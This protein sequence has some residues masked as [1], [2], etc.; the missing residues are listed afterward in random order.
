MRR[1][2]LA[3]A[4]IVTTLA[5]R[6]ALAE[7][8]APA[9]SPPAAA[10]SVAPVAC[11][12]PQLG[13]ELGATTSSPAEVLRLAPRVRALLGEAPDDAC[14]NELAKQ[15]YEFYGKALSSANEQLEAAST[16]AKRKQLT[17]ALHAVGWT[18]NASE[19]GDY[20]T[21]SKPWLPKAL[22]PQLPKLWR[23]YLSYSI[24]DRIA[25][26]SEDAGLRISWQQLRARIRRW[27]DFA[28]RY[29]DFPLTAGVR[30]DN[31]TV[32]R[33]FLSG[34]DNT[35]AFDAEGKLEPELKKE[36]EAYAADRKAARR[37]IVRGYLE[38]LAKH[39]GARSDASDAYLKKHKLPT[40]MGIEP[41]RF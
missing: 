4:T 21:E 41:P 28:A 39:G 36:L 8:A 6:V 38:V 11:A 37:A 27:E 15:F 10:G 7:P 31:D 35:P 29:P 16:D 33:I 14:R 34:I 2:A 9:P 18:I 25:G 13:T 26:L 32:F 30:E 12:A 20:V 23:E 24:G 22:G 19:A 40:M 5:L 1:Y 3:A 17:R